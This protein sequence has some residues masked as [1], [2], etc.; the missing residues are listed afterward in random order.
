VILKQDNYE[1]KQEYIKKYIPDW[2]SQEANGLNMSAVI[3]DDDWSQ[4]EK[5]VKEIDIQKMKKNK[6]NRLG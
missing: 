1:N 3:I 2:V 5:E 6:S 4:L